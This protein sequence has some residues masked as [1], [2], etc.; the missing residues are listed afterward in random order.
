MDPRLVGG[1]RTADRGRFGRLHVLSPQA[2]LERGYAIA[3]VAAGVLRGV[4]GIG[5]GERI[6]VQLAAGS[7]G[8]RVEEV[9]P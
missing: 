3:R 7:I 1:L 2:T 4:D 9:T 8:A 5:I 6:D